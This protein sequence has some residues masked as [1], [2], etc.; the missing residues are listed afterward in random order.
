MMANLDSRGQDGLSRQRPG[1]GFGRALPRKAQGKKPDRHD[2]R[3]SRERVQARM[4]Q[5]AASGAV[6]ADL[7]RA[8]P[9]VQ[10]GAED[11]RTRRSLRPPPNFRLKTIVRVFRSYTTS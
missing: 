9:D 11:P 2:P 7:G 4:Q 10:T 6:A 5:G 1:D 3:G 8:G